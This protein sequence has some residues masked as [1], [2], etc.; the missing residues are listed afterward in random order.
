MEYGY[1]KYQK[2]I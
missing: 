1:H 2:L